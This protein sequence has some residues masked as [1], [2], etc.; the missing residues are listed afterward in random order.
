MFFSRSVCLPPTVITTVEL[1]SCCAV[2]MHSFEKK[3]LRQF[4]ATQ[5]DAEEEILRAFIIDL[6]ENVTSQA[7]RRS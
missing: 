5:L 7:T 1:Y 2:H 3:T 4:S 6:P